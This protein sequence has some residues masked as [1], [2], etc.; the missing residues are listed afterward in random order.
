MDA[1]H[2]TQGLNRT[3]GMNEK[4]FKPK[5]RQAINEKDFES[6]QCW[7]DTF[8]STLEFDSEIKKLNMFYTYI[9]KNR[10]E[11]LI[12]EPPLKCTKVGY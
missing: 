4:I 10:I 3:F 1:Y 8:E 11:S 12:G 6:F 7:M 2:I 5:V 9:Q